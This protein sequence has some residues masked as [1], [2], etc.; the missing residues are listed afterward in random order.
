MEVRVRQAMRKQNGSS[1]LEI[2]VSLWLVLVVIFTPMLALASI[3]LRSTLLNIAVQDTVQG[4]AKARTF[5]L[6][7]ADGPSAKDLAQQIFS[8][9]LK[10][11][12]GLNAGNV[13]LEIISTDI[14]SG[15]ITRSP[16]KLSLPA[17]T[18]TSVYQ[19]EATAIAS[20]DPVFPANEQIFGK[21][22]G[23]TTPMNV[24]FS[25]RQMFE[26][27]QGLNR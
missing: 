22:P 20:I 26:N 24:K 2:P 6:A 13:A 19:L 12:S 23:F 9:H 7:S 25:A 14:N 4:A 5:E 18:N 15:V 1:I 16:S 27:T 8:E 10:A 17:D 21:I 3:T 11:F